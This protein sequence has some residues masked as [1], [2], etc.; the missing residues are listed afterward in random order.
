M[1]VTHDF[2]RS[3]EERR[4]AHVAGVVLPR[5]GQQVH[6]HLRAVRGRHT[7]ARHPGRDPTVACRGV[8]VPVRGLV[9]VQPRH[10]RVRG[11]VTGFQ[12]KH[13]LDYS[14]G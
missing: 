2:C 11:D 9:R 13:R 14:P 3:R 6:V 12:G 5:P 4:R 10:G 8:P 7:P 1:F